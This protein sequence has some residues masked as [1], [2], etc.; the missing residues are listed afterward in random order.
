MTTAHPA[1]RVGEASTYHHRCAADR[2]T[3]RPLASDLNNFLECPHLT[4]LDLAVVEGRLDAPDGRTARADLIARKGDEHEAAYLQSLKEAGKDVVEIPST[5]EGGARGS[6]GGDPRSHARRRRGHLPRRLP[7]RRLDRLRGLPPPRRRPPVRPRRLELR[8]R[9][10]EARPAHQ[11]LLPAPALLLQRAGRSPPGARAR[12]HPRH[13]RH[14]RA[15]QLPPRG[16]RRLL[17]QDQAA[18]PRRDRRLAA[19]HLPEP[20]PALRALPVGGALRRAAHRRR[21]PLP[22]RRNAK[23]TSRFA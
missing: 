18:L 13:P 14:A 15:A 1:R 7:P 12:A 21:P 11:A 17:P 16:V 4:Q 22:R 5:P 2:W 23:R 9:R 8:G 19:R 3:D 20:G 6:G 10:H